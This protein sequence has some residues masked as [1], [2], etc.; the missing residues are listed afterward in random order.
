LINEEYFN[1][2][3]RFAFERNKVLKIIVYNIKDLKDFGI[4][5]E[6]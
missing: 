3:E 6:Q 4:R 5:N 2:P 1:F